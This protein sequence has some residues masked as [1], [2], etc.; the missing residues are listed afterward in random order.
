MVTMPSVLVVRVVPPPP[1]KVTVAPGVTVTSGCPLTLRVASVP[2][3][4]AAGKDE[5]VRVR[6]GIEAVFV[7]APVSA[8]PRVRVMPVTVPAPSPMLLTV[9]VLPESVSVVFVPA[10]SVTVLPVAI[11]VLP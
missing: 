8:P 6:C 4:L 10:E 7:S 11:V 5:S 2:L 1:T 3:R 9:T